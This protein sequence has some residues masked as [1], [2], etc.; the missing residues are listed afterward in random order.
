MY[1]RTNLIH[2]THTIVRL[3]R[4][5]L[6]TFYFVNRWSMNL[7]LDKSTLFV[8]K[9]KSYG[10][11]Q[12]QSAYD[13]LIM[14]VKWHGYFING[15]WV[16]LIQFNSPDLIQE[17]V[18]YVQTC[19]E[20]TVIITDKTSTS[21]QT[22]FRGRLGWNYIPQVYHTFAKQKTRNIYVYNPILNV[23]I[24][25]IAGHCES[26]YEVNYEVYESLWEGVPW[27]LTLDTCWLFYIRPF[28]KYGYG[29]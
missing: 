20:N 22:S 13:N 6:Y 15:Y 9:H 3:Y 4:K 16:I 11:L 24:V 25:P 28:I 23:D 26:R 19:V 17:S 12:R 2:T 18:S 10:N 14:Y 1:S 27:R 5:A 21:I 7:Q 8:T 29:R